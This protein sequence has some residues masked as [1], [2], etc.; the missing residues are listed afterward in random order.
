MI[1]DNRQKV[2]KIQRIKREL[3]LRLANI[4]PLSGWK[5][6]YFVRRGG[7]NA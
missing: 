2:K 4:L 7:V 5:R 1:L 3:F 6:A